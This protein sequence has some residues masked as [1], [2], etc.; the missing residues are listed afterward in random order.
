[1]FLKMAIKDLHKVNKKI[2]R[3]K[4]KYYLKNLVQHNYDFFIAT[5]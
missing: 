3:E 4:S 2:K 1:M 5:C